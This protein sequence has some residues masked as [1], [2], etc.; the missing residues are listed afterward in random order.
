MKNTYACIAAQDYIWKTP[1]LSLSREVVSFESLE[2]AS[3][4]LV[5]EQTYPK[6]FHWRFWAFSRL[7]R[8]SFR[9]ALVCPNS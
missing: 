3:T 7:P 8:T 1:A 5:A 6:L 2:S 9:G 4:P